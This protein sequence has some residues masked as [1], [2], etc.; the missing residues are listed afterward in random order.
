MVE[1][2]G[3]VSVIEKRGVEWA[4][5]KCG[6]LVVN[7]DLRREKFGHFVNGVSSL[8]DFQVSIE[9]AASLLDDIVAYGD[10]QRPVD[11]PNQGEAAA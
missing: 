3:L 11:A 9:R 10:N 1:I 2:K 7:R 4:L 6:L 8:A 5:D